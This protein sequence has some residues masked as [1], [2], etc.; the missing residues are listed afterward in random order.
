VFLSSLKMPNNLPTASD[1]ACR[2]LIIS[3]TV[4]GVYYRASMVTEA[5]RLGISGWVRNRLDGSVE[6][7]LMGEGEAVAALIAWARKG[8]P[9]ARVDHI[10]VELCE[11]EGINTFEARE[12]A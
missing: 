5:Q 2:R 7:I 9:A 1:V 12:T 4:Q 10:L 3:G 8:P 6:A 11:E